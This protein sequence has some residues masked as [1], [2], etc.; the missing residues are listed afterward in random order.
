MFSIKLG[1]HLMLIRI[2]VTLLV[3]H[4]ERMT[5]AYLSNFS[6]LSF[7]QAPGK[8]SLRYALVPTR[9]QVL[10]DPF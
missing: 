4:S 9:L 5:A 10:V 1:E 7:F 8:R 2:V 6:L 3:C